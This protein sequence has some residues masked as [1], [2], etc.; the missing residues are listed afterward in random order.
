LIKDS[1]NIESGAIEA[2]SDSDRS[3]IQFLLIDIND[4]K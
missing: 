3:Q 1:I 2:K 4:E